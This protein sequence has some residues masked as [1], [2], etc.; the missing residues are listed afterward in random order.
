MASHQGTPHYSGQISRSRHTKR[1][2]SIH[3]RPRRLF[4]YK[5]IF[6]RR[7]C[8]ARWLSALNCVRLFAIPGRRSLFIRTREM[9]FTELAPGTEES[10]NSLSESL[11]IRMAVHVPTRLRIH[12]CMMYSIDCTCYTTLLIALKQSV[13]LVYWCFSFA[14][15]PESKFGAMKCRRTREN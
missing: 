5:V 13:S 11:T 7:L 14:D 9:P 2:H 8:C 4:S 10:F 3:K 1:Y 15:F 12:T 6:F